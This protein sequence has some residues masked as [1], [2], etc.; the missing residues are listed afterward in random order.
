MEVIGPHPA[1]GFDQSDQK[2]GVIK[3]RFQIF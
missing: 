2:H 3:S 1:C